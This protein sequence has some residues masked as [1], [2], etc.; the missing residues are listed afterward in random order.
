MNAYWERMREAAKYGYRNRS[1][2]LLAESIGETKEV[3]EMFGMPNRVAGMWM[4]ALLTAGGV[5][6][7]Y[8]SKN[9]KSLISPEHYAYVEGEIKGRTMSHLPNDAKPEM[10]IQDLRKAFRPSKVEIEVLL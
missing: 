10:V 6:Q 5:L 7:V 8:F 4:L 2:D 9:K 3:A 1:L